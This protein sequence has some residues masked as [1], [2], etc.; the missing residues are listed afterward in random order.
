M[1]LE[2]PR[3]TLAQIGAVALI[4]IAAVTTE[5]MLGRYPGASPGLGILLGAMTAGALY[6]ETFQSGR[7]LRRAIWLQD[8]TW[9]LEFVD[10]RVAAADLAPG[11]RT[12]GRTLVLRWRLAD[13][14]LRYWLTP[15]DIDEAILRTVTARLACALG[16]RGS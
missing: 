15:F 4:L 3:V 5:A 2:M 14:S 13:R 7:A 10:G 1:S 8:D 9:R 12:L 16:L 11:T 6:L